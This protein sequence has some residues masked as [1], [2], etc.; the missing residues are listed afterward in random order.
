[1]GL[2]LFS[3]VFVSSDAVY[4]AP[5]NVLCRGLH[6]AVG[7]GAGK[8]LKHVLINTLAGCDAA[9]CFLPQVTPLVIDDSLLAMC[10]IVA[11]VKGWTLQ[12]AARRLGNN[13]RA[14]Y[15]QQL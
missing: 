11:D 13:F 2:L 8:P 1:M 10:E 7:H 4:Q 6:L 15:Q 14:F 9:L 5:A 12:D 3:W